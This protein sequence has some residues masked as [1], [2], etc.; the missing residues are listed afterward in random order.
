MKKG[1]LTAAL[2]LGLAFI[3]GA[4]AS[5]AYAAG[6]KLNADQKWEYYDEEE[7]LLRNQWIEE[8]GRKFYVDGNGAMVRNTSAAVEKVW[9][10]FGEDGHLLTGGWVSVTEPPKDENSQPKVTWYYA[11][12]DGALLADGWHEADG[13]L[14]YFNKNGSCT[15]DGLVYVGS[16]RFYVTKDQG[17][18]GNTPGWFQ[19]ETE[20]SSGA[21]V[22]DWYYAKDDASI[23]YSSW[24]ED[25]GNWY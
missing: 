2:V 20:N 10:A 7:K 16:D 1:M 12:E 8:D 21:T 14:F 11:G 19:A 15:R 9:Y 6:W 18:L 5:S 22:V 17:R 3:S 24:L 4:A 25:G 13:K 23:Y